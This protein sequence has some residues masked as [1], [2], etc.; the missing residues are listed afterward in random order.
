MFHILDGPR[1]ITKCLN[2]QTQSGSKRGIAI[3]IVWTFLAGDGHLRRM[4]ELIGAVKRS[5]RCRVEEA[6][7]LRGKLMHQ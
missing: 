3:S 4:P 7:K 6:R 1:G 2:K 5:V